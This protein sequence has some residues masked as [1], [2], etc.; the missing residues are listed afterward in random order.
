MNTTTHTNALGMVEFNSIAVGIEAADAMLKVSQ[1]E[2]ITAKTICSGKYIAIVRGDTAAVRA[3][4]EEGRRVGGIAQVAD[5]PDP[6]EQC[7]KFGGL[8]CVV[9]NSNVEK[10]QEC[11]F[12]KGVGEPRR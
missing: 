8:I 3:S 7:Y 12:P 2:L 4:V 11:K 6:K 9:D 5:F 10:Y 1:V